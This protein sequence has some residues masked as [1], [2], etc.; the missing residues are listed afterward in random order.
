MQFVRNLAILGIHTYYVI[1]KVGGAGADGAAVLV[2]NMGGSDAG[3]CGPSVNHDFQFG[4]AG[5]SGSKV[6]DFVGPPNAVVRG[7]S[8]GRVFVTDDQGRVI[9]DITRDRVKP[10]VPG[11]GFESG[12]D[13]KLTPT[14]TQLEWINDLWG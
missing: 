1:P 9:F 10:V 8:E 4:G 6:K 5:R 11:R 2:H 12:S 13:R 3:G 14:Q 7:A